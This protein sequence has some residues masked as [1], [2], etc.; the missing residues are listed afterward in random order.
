[1]KKVTVELTVKQL[2]AL[3]AYL[4][5]LQNASGKPCFSDWGDLNWLEV[6]SLNQ[7]YIKLL[8]VTPR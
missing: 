1:M 7:A 3:R 5:G 4:R 6:R 8:A 2:Y